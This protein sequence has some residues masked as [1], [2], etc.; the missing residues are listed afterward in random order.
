MN[1]V[2]SRPWCLAITK[3]TET[4][5]RWKADRRRAREKH[6]QTVNLDLSSSYRGPARAVASVRLPEGAQQ[7]AACLDEVFASSL[8]L[9][10]TSTRKVAASSGCLPS[11]SFR[12]RALCA[13]GRRGRY[14]SPRGPDT[15]P[16]DEGRPR[17]PAPTPCAHYEIVVLSRRQYDRRASNLVQS[18]HHSVQTD[19][20]GNTFAR[21]TEGK[22]SCWRP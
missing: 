22:L 8:R 15:P 16:R 14:Y 13:S 6:S 21:W 20:L 5:A 11:G 9:P 4:F 17:G 12:P 2:P 7:A 19:P 10:P 3:T 1:D 18:R